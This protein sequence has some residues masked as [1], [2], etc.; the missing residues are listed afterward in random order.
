MHVTKIPNCYVH[1][2][3]YASFHT[4]QDKILINFSSNDLWTTWSSFVSNI[5]LESIDT[6]QLLC[7]LMVLMKIT[8]TT[9]N[10]N[11]WINTVFLFLDHIIDWLYWTVASQNQ[12]HHTLNKCFRFMDHNYSK[13]LGFEGQL[14]ITLCTGKQTKIKCQHSQIL[15]IRLQL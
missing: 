15:E 12:H 9:I 4:K 13:K 7:L 5:T 14:F 6:D 11:L 3:I 8:L 2:K 10:S 1:F